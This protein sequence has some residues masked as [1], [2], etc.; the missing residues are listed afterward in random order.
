[1]KQNIVEQTNPGLKKSLVGVVSS[2]KMNKT[3]VVKVNRKVRH[4]LYKKYIVRTRKFKAHDEENQAK[5]GDLVEIVE[6]RPL[7]KDK[8]WALKKIVRKST[9]PVVALVD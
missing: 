2:D 8:R 7:S 3:I 6:C 9:G 5:A 1:M 4:D